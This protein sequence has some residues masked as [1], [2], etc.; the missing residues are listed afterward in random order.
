MSIR[1]P[2]INQS[3]NLLQMQRVDSTL[4]IQYDPSD[5][6][7]KMPELKKKSVE[8]SNVNSN[9]MSKRQHKARYDTSATTDLQSVAMKHQHSK[10]SVRPGSLIDLYD[11]QSQRAPSNFG[12]EV[13]LSTKQYHVVRNKALFGKEDSIEIVPNNVSLTQKKLPAVRMNLQTNRPLNMNQL[14][15]ARFENINKEPS[16]LS[17]VKRPHQVNF[18][19]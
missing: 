16:I 2:R 3:V 19:N 17:T 8:T 18:K 5:V 14:N 10:S 12:Y 4:S 15:D 9:V 1:K 7:I 6:Q 11:N 13:E